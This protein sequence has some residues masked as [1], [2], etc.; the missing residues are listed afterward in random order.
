MKVLGLAGSPRRGGNTDLLLAEMIRGASDSGA[1]TRVIIIS[2]LKIKTC[3]HCDRCMENG[4]CVIKDD[5]QL[6]YNNMEEADG[7]ILASPVQFMGP[8]A[9]LKTV[10]DRCQMFWARKYVLKRSPLNPEK[11][12]RGFF[13]S[14]G[15]R[16]I[17]NLFEPSLKIVQTFFRILNITYAGDL[18]FN[19][20]D[21]KGAIT[22]KPEA[23]NQSYLAGKKFV[24][25][26]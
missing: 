4:L 15:G 1:E 17:S 7:I 23:L 16:N 22:R 18:L 19:G 11:E 9:E 13:I 12:R 24:L 26:V 25:S 3:Q 20:I 21:E 5:M 2:E 8:T 10:I 6:I 14:V